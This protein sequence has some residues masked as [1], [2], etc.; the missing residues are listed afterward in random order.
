MSAH[1]GVDRLSDGAALRLAFSH[2]KGNVLTSEL[3]A[4]VDAALAEHAADPHLKLVLLE[5]VGK[6][7]SLG[8]SI[9]EHDKAHVAGMLASF[10]SLVR[11]LATY[12]V[13]TAALVRGRCLGGAL[14]LAL[15]C[16]FVFAARS[17]VFACPE[18][19]LGVFPP[20][21]AALGPMRIG[22][23][24]TERLAL[25][26]ADLDADT[27]RAIGLVT[28]VVPDGVDVLERAVVWFEATLAKR[29]AF[30]LRR[31]L[32][33]VRA[34]SAVGERV[35]RTLG[36]IERQYLERVVPSFDGNEGIDAFLA[37]R[38]PRW[39]DA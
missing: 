15:S 29:S 37:K 9:D 26:G 30:A 31:T 32:E 7:F 16:N 4:R 21:L 10:H 28:E 13:A 5:G 24:W 8:A 27:A 22:A 2:E 19:T 1:V 36:E 20:V 14:E 38:E 6:H 17:A 3:L 23:A 35:T 11:R 18:I 33:A 39:R 12:P 25:T 34:G